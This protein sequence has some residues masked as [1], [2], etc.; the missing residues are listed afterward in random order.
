LT[1]DVKNPPVY[2]EVEIRAPLEM[3]WARTHEPDQH[4]RWDLRFS[5]LEYLPRAREDEPQRLL[6][7]TRIGFGLKVRGEGAFIGTKDAGDGSRT[8]ALRFWCS[9]RRSLIRSGSGYW[10][11]IP[12]ERG[13]TF[14]TRY[15]YETRFG[16]AGAF[17]DRLVFRPLLGWATAWSFDR[18]RLWL[19]QGIQPDVARRRLLPRAGRCRRN[20][21]QQASA[22][23]AA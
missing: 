19:E 7:T 10:R 5:Q 4:A 23:S 20:R 13:V 11:Y 2:V 14:L 18:L 16:H 6:Y 17:V 12:T 8:T 21:R 1:H 3:V 15:D 22:T 9:D